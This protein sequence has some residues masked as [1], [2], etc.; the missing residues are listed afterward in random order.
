MQLEKTFM[1]IQDPGRPAE[2]HFWYNSLRQR[3]LLNH[4]L[5]NCWGEG[6]GIHS[7]IHFW[8]GGLG[9]SF[10]YSFVEGEDL[11]VHFS[12]HL[13]AGRILGFLFLINCWRGGLEDSVQ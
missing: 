2:L 11:G 7:S 6:L 3:P 10:F 13:L 4:S 9:E 8:G 5:F 1:R 12:I